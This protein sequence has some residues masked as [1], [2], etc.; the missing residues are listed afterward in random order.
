M[1]E[2]FRLLGIPGQRLVGVLHPDFLA[3]A[4]LVPA[5]ELDLRGLADGQR[6]QAQ[7]HAAVGQLRDPLCNL[8][9]NFPCVG[10]PVDHPSHGAALY[11]TPS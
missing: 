5:V 9:P 7:A 8:A 2:Q 6:V 4:P 11:L 3:A 1:T 10:P